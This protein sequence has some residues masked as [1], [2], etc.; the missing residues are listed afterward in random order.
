MLSI[1]KTTMICSMAM[2]DKI[3]VGR[4]VR[5]GGKGGRGG[6]SLEKGGREEE[7][8]EASER[9]RRGRNGSG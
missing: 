3:D 2:G 6:Q 8:D 7:E 4:E 5:G 9:E 1:L